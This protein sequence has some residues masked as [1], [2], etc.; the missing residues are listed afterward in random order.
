MTE[1]QVVL[2]EL[3]GILHDIVEGIVDAQPDMRVAADIRDA[4][5]VPRSLGETGA[6]FVIWG[7]DGDVAEFYPDVLDQYPRVKVLAVQNEY[8]HALLWEMRPTPARLGELS[9]DRLVAALRTVG[10]A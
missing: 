2:V 4:G 10:D 9:P 1:V 5:E 8:H 3:S 6:Q 7:I